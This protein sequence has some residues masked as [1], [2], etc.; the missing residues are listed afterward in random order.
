MGATRRGRPLHP[1]TRKGQIAAVKGRPL[2]D[3]HRRKIREALR[4]STSA[5]ESSIG[6]FVF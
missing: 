1:N 3:E 4:N 2:S 5:K 6:Y